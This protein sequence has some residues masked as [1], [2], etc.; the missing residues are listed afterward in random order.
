MKFK[1]IEALCDS[2]L[3]I[4]SPLVSSVLGVAAGEVFKFTGIFQ[5]IQQVSAYE[6]TKTISSFSVGNSLTSFHST[7]V[8]DSLAGLRI[9]MIGAGA[10]GSEFAKSTALINMCSKGKLMIFD[11]D[12]IEISNL[13]RQFFFQRCDVGKSKAVAL[14][15]RIKE[16]RP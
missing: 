1:E 2:N 4:E 16:I 5:P 13:N 8:L 15:Q 11:D 9:A 14:A 7:A 12:L 10:S 3:T 6:V